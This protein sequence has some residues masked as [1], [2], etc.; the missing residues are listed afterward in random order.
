MSEQIVDGLHAGTLEDP[1]RTSIGALW[2]GGED[3]ESRGADLGRLMLRVVAGA[4]LLL[5]HGVGKVPPSE[6]F[7]ANIARMGFPAPDLFAWLASLAEFVGGLLLALGLLTRPAALLVTGH[8]LLVLVV[9]HAG[10]PFADREKA[11]LYGVVALFYLL[12][13]AGRYSLD[14]LIRRRR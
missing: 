12:A 8:F 4:S 14:A 7:T 10:A 9:A 6:G 1:P 2:F 5:A 3:F 11:V 13:G